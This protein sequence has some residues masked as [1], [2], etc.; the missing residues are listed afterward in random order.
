M[1]INEMVVGNTY[2]MR[3]YGSVFLNSKL[4]AV[5][6][7]GLANYDI[8][9]LIQPVEALYAK[10]F[11]SLAAALNSDTYQ[12]SYSPKTR[13]YYLFEQQN[14]TKLV[15]ADQWIVEDSVENV[16]SVTYTVTIY[17]GNLGETEKIAAAMAAIGKTNY[18]IN[19]G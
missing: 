17:D 18:T 12:I 15:L 13:Q 2:A 4:D 14:G 5:K 3:L 8:A 7:I 1:K 10:I 9:N 11:P 6:L 16:S 19:V